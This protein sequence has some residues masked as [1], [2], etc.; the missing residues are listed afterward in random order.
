[1]CLLS[2]AV[3]FCQWY[4]TDIFASCNSDGYFRASASWLHLLALLIC[5]WD[6]S[7]VRLWK[8]LVGNWG[9]HCAA[10]VL[11][12]GA[13]TVGQASV[14]SSC[15]AAVASNGEEQS[16]CCVLWP[17]A[18]GPKAMLVTFVTWLNIGNTLSENI[19]CTEFISICHPSDPCVSFNSRCCTFCVGNTWAKVAWQLVFSCCIALSVW[20]V[21]LWS[22]YI[23][24][25]CAHCS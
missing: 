23:F 25:S 15:A 3:T 2:R 9:N 13:E 22:I 7:E 11:F 10:A 19:H 14:A 16:S 4:Q 12:N 6:T 5:T 21:T 24:A 20:C 17:A 18:A 1:M 8:S